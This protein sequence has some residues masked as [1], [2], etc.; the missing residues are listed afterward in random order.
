MPSSCDMFQDIADFHEHIVN[1]HPAPTPSLISPE[2]CMERIR[3]LSEE[4]TELTDSA[5]VGDI[6]GV[7]DALADL[8][9]VAMGT[10]YTMGMNFDEIWRAV[11]DANMRKVQ[12]MTKRGNTH[13]AVKL[14]GWVGPE[15]AIART[16]SRP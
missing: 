1:V 12:G 7:A 5:M 6:V 11:H 15:A 3:F 2:F 9:Y 14:L 4:L 8:V 13:D 16:L 10:A